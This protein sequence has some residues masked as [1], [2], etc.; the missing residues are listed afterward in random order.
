MYGRKTSQEIHDMMVKSQFKLRK[1]ELPSGISVEAADFITKCLQRK[2][3]NRLGHNK[4]PSEV[5]GHIWFDGFDWAML[6]Q[7]LIP[8]PLTIFKG[9]DN[10]DPRVAAK[11]YIP[12][13]KEVKFMELLE[14][15]ESL[16]EQFA[17]FYYNKDDFSVEVRKIA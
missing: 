10:Y 4:G 9:K 16:Q 7:R 15:D 6:Q 8:S 2:P 14:K 12:S 1:A 17:H 11:K 3:E 13:E 5:R